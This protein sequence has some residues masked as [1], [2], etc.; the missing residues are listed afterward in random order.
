MFRCVVIVFILAKVR[1][2]GV[3]DETQSVTIA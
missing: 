2:H 3:N 1:D